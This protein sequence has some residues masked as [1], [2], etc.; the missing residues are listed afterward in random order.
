MSE[1][2][3]IDVSSD[4]YIPEVFGEELEPNYYCRGR[5]TKRQKY[6]RSRAG[7]RT[8]H[9]GVGRCWVHGGRNDH[10]LKHGLYRRYQLKSEDREKRLEH[11]AQD[12]APLDLSAELALART[13]LSEWLERDNTDPADGLALVDR[14]TRIVERIEDIDAKNHITYPQ[15]KRFLWTVAQ[16]LEFYITDKPTLLKIREALVSVRPPSG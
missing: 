9:P 13:L 1:S 15:L 8:E 6:C 10:Q 12:P 16:I 5:N 11:H 7:M 2:T 3:A 14:V 4:R